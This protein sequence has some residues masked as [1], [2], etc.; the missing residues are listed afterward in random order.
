MISNTG[1]NHRFL[2]TTD[3]T[4]IELEAT[5]WHPATAMILRKTYFLDDERCYSN[6]NAFVSGLE[7]TK[8]TFI[9]NAQ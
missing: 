1:G 7:A 3:Y 2:L 8:R 5:N 4:T 9:R 6:C